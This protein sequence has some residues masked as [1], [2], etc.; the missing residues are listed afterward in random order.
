M[1]GQELTGE[2]R[3][4]SWDLVEADT[5]LAIRQAAANPRRPDAEAGRAGGASTLVVS[6]G[7][8]P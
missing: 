5:S 1:R 4:A 7:P 2:I 8:T 3:A 6:A